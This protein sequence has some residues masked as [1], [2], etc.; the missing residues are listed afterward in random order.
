MGAG[1]STVQAALD[2]YKAPLKKIVYA[3]RAPPVVKPTT[4]AAYGLLQPLKEPTSLPETRIVQSSLRDGATSL[5]T[6]ET[7]LNLISKDSSAHGASSARQFSETKLT[8]DPDLVDSSD[9]K[10][11]S[12]LGSGVNDFDDIAHTI[13]EAEGLSESDEETEEIFVVDKGT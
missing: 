1:V 12:E 7:D 5:T 6:G 2:Y 10:S 3:Y 4:S 11:G 9:S 8:L 13:T